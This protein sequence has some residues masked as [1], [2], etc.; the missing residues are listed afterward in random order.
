MPSDP[1]AGADAGDALVAPMPR[2]PSPNSS[3]SMP[4]QLT[5]VHGEVA[6]AHQA[7]RLA[8]GGPVERLGDGARQSTTTG[9]AFSSATARRPM[10]KLSMPFS[11]RWLGLV[12]RGAVDPAEHQRGVAQV[13]LVSRLNT[14]SSKTSRS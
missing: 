4:E 1:V 14:A 10:W 8:A 6:A 13:E 9:S 11:A 2:W 7:H 5:T 3:S 12:I